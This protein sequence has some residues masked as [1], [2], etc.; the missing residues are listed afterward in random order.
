MKT[1]NPLRSFILKSLLIISTLCLSLLGQEITVFGQVTTIQGGALLPVPGAAIAIG[2]DPNMGAVSGEN[3]M[4]ELTFL[5]LWDGPVTATCSAEGYETV[6][7]TFFPNANEYELNFSLVSGWFEEYSMLTGFVYHTDCGFFENCPVQGAMVSAWNMNSPMD[8]AF[9]TYTGEW[10]HYELELPVMEEY[11]FDWM[12]SVFHEDYIYQSEQVFID[13]EGA[14][15]DFY[16]QPLDDPDPTTG[17]YGYVYQTSPNGLVLPVTDAFIEV[18]SNDPSQNEYFS[19]YSNDEGYFEIEFGPGSYFLSCTQF[20]FNPFETEFWVGNVPQ[21]LTIM[22]EQQWMDETFFSGH[23]FAMDG[24]EVPSFYG[25]D[26][27]HVSIISPMTNEVF[28]DTYSNWGGFYEFFAEDPFNP[29]PYDGPGL[30]IVS[31]DGFIGQ[32]MD[33]DFSDWPVEQDFYLLPEETGDASLFGY[34][35]ATSEDG[36]LMP[37]GGATVQ[38]YGGFTG[39]LL[40]ETQTNEAGYYAFDDVAYA[41]NFMEVT[42]PGYI[43]QEAALPGYSEEPIEVDFYLLP[44]GDPNEPGW[45]FGMVTAQASP[46]GP[47]YPLPGITVTAAHAWGEPVFETVTNDSGEYEMELPA[48]NMPWIVTCISPYGQQS[49]EV[50]IEPDQGTELNFHFNVWEEQISPP[51]DVIASLDETNQMILLNWEP[52]E[53][54]WLNCPPIYQIYTD[55]FPSPDGSWTVIGQTQDLSFQHPAMFPGLEIP[56]EVCFYVTA[57]C[58]DIESEPSNISCV[59]IGQ[60]FE[61]GG[62]NGWVTVQFSEEGPTIPVAGAFISATPAWGP[63]PNPSTL[64]GEDG[65]YELE[66]WSS[67]IPWVVHCNTEYGFQVAEVVIAPGDW[68]NLNF[69]FDVWQFPDFSPP[70]N[71]MAV[72]ADDHSHLMLSWEPPVFWPLNCLPDYRIYANW[73][74]DPSQEF[75]AV[76]ETSDLSWV[77]YLDFPGEVPP[78]ICFYVTAFCGEDETAPSNTACVSLEV[79]LNMGTLHGMVTY[80]WGD[81]IELIE[82][83]VITAVNPNHPAVYTAVSGPEGGYEMQLPAGPYQVSCT[84]ESGEIQTAE[85]A[86]LPEMVTQL[87]FEFGQIW[88]FHILTGMVY[89]IS[90]FGDMMP[91]DDAMLRI[92]QGEFQVVVYTTEGSFWVELPGPGVYGVEIEAQGYVGA[93]EEVFVQG[94]SEYEFSLDP[95]D[96]MF[97][98]VIHVGQASGLPGGEVEVPI[99]IENTH[100]VGGIQF[101]LQDD[102]DILT[103]IMLSTGEA[104]P[105]FMGSFNEVEGSVIGV[106]FSLQ[107]CVIEPGLHEVARLTY[108][109][110]DDL[111]VGGEVA[112]NFTDA[113]ISD[114]DGNSMPVEWVNGS[115]T[116]GLTGDLNNDAVIDVLDIVTLVNLVIMVEMPD[117]YQMWAGDLNGDTEL[118]ILDIV[119]LVNLILFGDEN[120]FGYRSTHGE[121]ELVQHASELVI[122]GENIAGFQIHATGQFQIDQVYVDGDWEFAMNNSILLGY[123]KD[124]AADKISIQY[125]GNLEIDQVLL[126]DGS[127][128]EI[129]LD[130]IL[131]PGMF[132]L[133]QNYPNPFNPGTEIPFTILEAANVELTVYDLQGRQV[134]ILVE[135]YYAAGQYVASWNGRDDS[136]NS[137]PAGMYLC[138]LQAGSS[139]ERIKMILLK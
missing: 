109:I 50:F 25:L 93:Y 127:G 34:V 19:T 99:G 6:S 52:P 90:V 46:M 85:A 97:P 134:S 139:L 118:N 75:I 36:V 43:G 62:I 28:A 107:G 106:I 53:I 23:V 91:L 66:L 4:Y 7:E 92:S 24:G 57:G 130:A 136:G 131:E 124:F 125:S 12:V 39:G 13:G 10:G 116:I 37:L 42:A 9:T 11:G 84:L 83:A 117:D 76:D 108:T 1:L 112:L 114:P 26:G 67:E 121:A 74:G 45:L 69:H 56:T 110:S 96:N 115:V 133:K 8:I 79:P 100:P 80:L 60:P 87:N 101:T 77:H 38:I 123:T 68:V 59:E 61:D 89:G 81:A 58:P 103:A 98:V 119:Q 51:V 63:E 31:A 21:Q 33:I 126:S 105:C 78:V 47:S 129:H 128:S 135:Q 82:G 71:L 54:W 65:F 14:E 29:W 16:I 70:H 55:A 17:V 64:T 30:V 111:P 137:V 2:D 138:Q 15:H 94:I 22:L 3:G 18:W 40:S 27:A 48:G 32:E 73:S 41:A 102:P 44:T 113:I 35:Y 95:L 86:I 49:A 5:W 120:G 104:E 72:L 132:S 88:E 122:Q 20:G